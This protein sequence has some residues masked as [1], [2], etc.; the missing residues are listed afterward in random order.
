MFG[1][2]PSGIVLYS[3]NP[4]RSSDQSG[5]YGLKY[6]FILTISYQDKAVL[7]GISMRLQKDLGFFLQ[8]LSGKEIE[9]ASLLSL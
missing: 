4:G 2:V 8:R 3:F 1:K 7:Y 6:G 5:L 9:D